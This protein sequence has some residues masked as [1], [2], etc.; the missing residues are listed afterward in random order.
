MAEF[1]LLLFFP[2]KIEV[3]LTAQRLKS[4][5]FLSANELSRRLMDGVGLSLCGCD[6][7]QLG[8]Q[9]SSRSKVVRMVCLISMH[10]WYAS[11]MHRSTYASPRYAY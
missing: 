5:Q 3:E 9:V 10:V 8:D 6:F 11:A 4:L 7:H 1:R 2:V